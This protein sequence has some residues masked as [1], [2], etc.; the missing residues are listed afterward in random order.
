MD[1][2]PSTQQATAGPGLRGQRTARTV[3][4]V[5][6]CI[7]APLGVVLV[8]VGFYR[9]VTIEPTFDGPP[10]G[11]FMFAAGG[12]MA[13][14]GVGFLNA[15]LLGT[16]ARY[17]AGETMPVVKDSAS[18]LTDGEGVLGVGRTVDDGRPTTAPTTGSATG[19]FCRTCGT[20]N[21]Q[22]ARF[23]DGCGRPLA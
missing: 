6:G 23:C 21:D 13:V 8:V 11:L 22:E 15:G 2:T 14:F 18:Y 10:S 17:S 16:A 12:F 3:F 20:R 5:L 9:F 4:R 7:L 1:S 19:P